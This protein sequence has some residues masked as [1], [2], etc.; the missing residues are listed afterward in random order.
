VKTKGDGVFKIRGN[1]LY[2]HGSING[3]FYRKSTGK[4]V[5]PAVKQWI[6]KADPLKVLAELLEE[7]LPVKMDNDLES[8]GLSVL[9]LT[10]S[11]RGVQT[12]KDVERI[13]N[14]RILPHF[15]KYRMEDIKPL[16]IVKF[17]ELLKKELSADR[18]R[19]I[20]NTFNMIL[21]FAEENGLILKN[22][23][24]TRTVSQVD[25]SYSKKNT[26][27][28]DTEEIK[29]ILDNA[30]GW[31]KVFMDIS[32][33]LGLR[34]GEA[35]AL[36]WEDINLETGVLLLRRSIT[37]GI[38]SEQDID[39]NS[40]KNHFRKIQILPE[41]LKLL[42]DY[43][44]VR[45]SDEWLFINKDSRY[46]RESKTIVDYHLKPLLKKIGVPYKTLYATR[47]SYASI[48]K[49]AGQDLESIQEVMGHSKGSKITEKHYIDPR[50]L[51]LSHA[52]KEAE[53]QEALF[54][55]MIGET[56]VK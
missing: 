32:F 23:I 24:S 18:V 3:K 43:Y 8:F 41:T 2:V 27:A 28:Y 37:R 33:K 21:D 7:E 30:K 1:K 14:K 45:P 54:N 9:E 13:F 11:K 17:L 29:L 15:K 38:V 42:N 39:S 12:Q 10:S 48:M 25:L 51:K 16:D 19:R 22:P 55:V 53:K 47:R 6:K 20:K 4:K 52:Q 26:Q 36:K 49:F 40:N 44:N 50:I 46:F 56:K 35:M 5:T 31:F 34:T